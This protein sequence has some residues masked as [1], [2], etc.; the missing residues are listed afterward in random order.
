MS[1]PCAHAQ[2]SVN[3]WARGSSAP[4]GPHI[5]HTSTRARFNRTLWQSQRV[6]IPC[7]LMAISSFALRAHVKPPAFRAGFAI[8]LFSLSNYWGIRPFGASPR[9]PLASEVEPVRRDRCQQGAH[10]GDVAQ[11]ARLPVRR[12]SCRPIGRKDLS[13]S[14]S[15]SWGKW[16]SL[17]PTCLG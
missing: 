14:L 6:R 11:P 17:N 10:Q 5:S 7:S 12:G 9:P 3:T 8:N 13:L 4:S 16:L 15:V 1:G 2:P